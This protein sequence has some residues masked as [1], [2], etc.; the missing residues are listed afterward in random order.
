[1]VIGASVWFATWSSMRWP[2]FTVGFTSE[3]ATPLGG[4]SG[5][6]KYAIPACRSSATTK[7]VMSARGLKGEAG[8]ASPAGGV[9]AFF[10]IGS[11]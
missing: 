2:G 10:A 5:V 9:D 1:M 11:Q 6:R 4:A 8:F 3:S 7:I